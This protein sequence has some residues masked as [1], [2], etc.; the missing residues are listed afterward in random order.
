[1]GQ[2]TVRKSHPARGAWIETKA[3]L[4]NMANSMGRTPPGVRGLKRSAG[5]SAIFYNCRTP[6]GVRGLKHHRHGR[7]VPFCLSHPARGAWIETD[8]KAP[9]D[10]FDDVAPR[11]GCV[12]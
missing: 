9:S 3:G 11:P 6:P 8:K 2:L 10:K 4:V 1:M 12:D 5:K 7:D